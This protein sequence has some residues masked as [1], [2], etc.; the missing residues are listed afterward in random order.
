MKAKFQFSP[1]GGGQGV[2]KIVLAAA[3]LRFAQGSLAIFNCR[4]IL[5]AFVHCVGGGR[6]VSILWA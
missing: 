1:A 4:K 6:K 3:V 5:E 2:E